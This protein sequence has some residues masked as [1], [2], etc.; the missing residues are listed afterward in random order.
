MSVICHL[1]SLTS[2]DNVKCQMSAMTDDGNNLHQYGCLQKRLCK[3]SN[4]VKKLNW[5]DRYVRNDS[6]Y[7]PHAYF[8]LYIFGISFIKWK[9]VAPENESLKTLDFFW[10]YLFRYIY[11]SYF[12]SSSCIAFHPHITTR[13]FMQQKHGRL[14]H[15]FK[16]FGSTQ[17]ADFLYKPIFP[18]KCTQTFPQLKG[19]ALAQTK[20][21]SPKEKPLAKA[22]N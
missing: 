13:R 1:S 3:C 10:F 22:F 12:L 16:C 4:L 8:P 11:L 7:G 21:T 15:P 2:A 9:C 5:L 17:E 20:N 18:I 6:Q 14:G 19:L